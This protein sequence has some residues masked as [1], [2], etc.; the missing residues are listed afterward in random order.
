MAG[1]IPRSY[2]RPKTVT[3]PG[4]NQARRGLTSFMRRTPLCAGILVILS[5]LF[6][7]PLFN[8]IPDASLAAV[9]IS[10]VYDLIDFTLLPKLWRVNS[11]YITSLSSASYVGC[12]RGTARICWLL[13]AV[14][15][16]CA[17]AE[18]AVQHRATSISPTRL[19]YSIYLQ[20]L[21]LLVGR[22]EWHPA[23]QKLEW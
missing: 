2:T 17:A 23:C 22:Q 16:P 15:R 20:C 12:R 6:L 8:Y 5:L 18:P 7:T 19:A 3:Y 9:I 21:T 4:T 11:T 1:Y 13:R 14:L 10:A